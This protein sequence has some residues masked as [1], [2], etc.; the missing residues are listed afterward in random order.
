VLFK[1]Y[2][3]DPCLTNTTLQLAAIPDIN[4]FLGSAAKTH[5]IQAE[6][7]TN[8]TL[9]CGNIEFNFNGR[10]FASLSSTATSATISVY[11]NNSGDIGTYEMKIRAKLTD[12]SNVEEV[13]SLF[14][15]IIAMGSCSTTTL[16]LPSTLLDVTITS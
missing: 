16:T 1:V 7:L 3:I 4:Y 6:V 15:I 13:E 5:E 12:Y 2:V 8:K 11:S 9:L 14:K 10:P